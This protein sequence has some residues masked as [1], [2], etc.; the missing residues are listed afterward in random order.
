MEKHWCMIYEQPQFFFISLISC[1]HINLQPK[2]EKVTGVRPLITYYL[3][4][5]IAK[6]D[7]ILTGHMHNED[8]PQLSSPHYWP[9]L[10]GS[11][12]YGD[13]VIHQVRNVGLGQIFSCGPKHAS[14]QNSNKF[15]VV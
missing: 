12:Q 1:Y 3:N 10:Q 2:V 4:N 8:K 11:P 9:L 6:F 15:I 7:T 13:F 5:A 14:E